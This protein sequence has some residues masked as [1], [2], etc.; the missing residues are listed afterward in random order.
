M[1]Q[2]CEPAQLLIVIVLTLILVRGGFAMFVIVGV[3]G[4]KQ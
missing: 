1:G 4:G 3:L 2:L